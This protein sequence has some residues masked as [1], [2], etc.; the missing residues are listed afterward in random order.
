MRTY[1]SS[2][3]LTVFLL[4]FSISF[5]NAQDNA[6]EWQRYYGGNLADEIQMTM[7]SM[8]GELIAVGTTKSKLFKGEDV[9][10]RI[11]DDN[12]EVIIK[13]NF[14]GKKND[15]ASAFVQTYDGGYIVVGYT[16]SKWVDSHGKRD[17][18]MVKTD[19]YGEPIWHHS[20]GGKRDDEFN[21]VI[22]LEN[23]NL[24]AVGHQDNKPF[25]VCVSPDGKTVVWESQI[26]KSGSKIMALTTGEDGI[27][28][29]AGTSGKGRRTRAF[30]VTL[31]QT[32]NVVQR[33]K[34][35]NDA[36]IKTGEDI[37]RDVY[38]GQF[39]IAGQY[40]S[41]TQRE[42]LC[43]AKVDEKGKL[44]WVKNYGG[45]GMDATESLIQ[46]SA[47]TF[48]LAG[49]SYSHV[50]GARRSRGWVKF[51][52]A[53]GKVI[54]EEDS[55]LG[56]VQNDH[57]TAVNE[58]N[59]GSLL[60]AGASASN[61]GL[62][63]DAWLVKAKPK[64][65]RKK[66]TNVQLTISDIA[67][68]EEIKND[69]L[70]AEERGYISFR[71]NNSTDNDYSGL[72]ALIE[73][74]N[75]V[76]G[77]M[78]DE[79]IN[80]GALAGSDSRKLSVPVV[81]D[82]ELVTGGTK[83]MIKI[84]DEKGNAVEQFETEL[85]TKAKP[86]PLLEFADYQFITDSD[87][88][89]RNEVIKLQLTVKNNGNAFA[90]NAGIRVFLP[91]R[92]KLLSEKYIPLGNMPAGET[93]TVDFEFKAKSYYQFDSILVR[94]VAFEKTARRGS[95]DAFGIKIKNF[96]D[97]EDDPDFIVKPKNNYWQNTSGENGGPL[98]SDNIRIEVT[99]MYWKS[100]DQDEDG[101]EINDLKSPNF[102]IKIRVTSTSQLK[103]EDFAIYIN[104]EKGKD[105]ET[106]DNQATALSQG[107][108]FKDNS[109][110]YIF[111]SKIIVKPGENKI[112]V[113]VKT[114]E[115]SIDSEP[116]IVN[117]TLPRHNLHIFAFGVPHEDLDF[118]SKDAKDFVG[119]FKNQSGKLFDEV[120][121]FPFTVKEKTTREVIAR[122]IEGLQ[123]EFLIEETIKEGDA[124]IFYFSS[125]GF[126]RAKKPKEFRIA[127]SDFDY[128]LQ[129]STSIEFEDD[130]IDVL[131][132]LENIN[133]YI[134]IDACYSGAIAN[135]NI[136]GAKANDDPV[137]KAVS[138]AITE[139]AASTAGYNTIVSCSAGQLSYE[140]PEW[141]NSSFTKALLEG[142]KNE[143]VKGNE[144]MITTDTDN[145]GVIHTDELYQFLQERVPVIVKTARPKIKDT[146]KPFM[147]PKHIE[148]SR[149][150]FVVK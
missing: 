101:L 100:P 28:A 60:F 140:D 46:T 22:Q 144:G 133:K 15:A 58:L 10:F 117:Y 134:F 130:V 81:G 62:D 5:I 11:L 79:S 120:N 39:A 146:Q 90:E 6:S 16:D 125:H 122:Q 77:L 54:K 84:V 99:D 129:K 76:S 61:P 45:F 91:E 108:S 37:V 113:K 109:F 104:G 70:D 26:R 86:L 88:P 89:E 96:Y 95:K 3:S 85:K 132:D 82:L 149:P 19:E 18:W 13:Q 114:K 118:S 53:K 136:E 23:G 59:D 8:Q 29:M 111:H 116:V 44:L 55:Y 24:V 121:V 51:I 48:V 36:K 34:T 35:I 107:K 1:T 72:R 43:L 32:G 65:K 75:P 31:D 30:F 7:Q 145:N 40:D 139:L 17:A 69:S 97:I 68:N 66:N 115:G 148:D 56:G 106:V 2:L 20:Y 112:V 74:E 12:G 73:V 78:I 105:E 9:L 14:G 94:A 64:K 52:D 42:D 126:T 128:M 135:Q 71:L 41:P 92:V 98:P 142:F 21:D 87:L 25:A 110:S 27:L 38:N 127:A 147:P 138:E 93:R 49:K 33:P 47:G 137:D 150:L 124:I 123:N 83:A 57:F 63:R 103:E 67:W 4:L 119:A 102:P 141:G 80:L 131:D 50:R 143:P